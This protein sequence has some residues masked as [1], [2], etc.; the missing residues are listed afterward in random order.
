[1]VLNNIGGKTS[2]K[3]N[4][5]KKIN[6]VLDILTLDILCKYV[7]TQSRIIRLNHLVNLR[8]MIL[9]L[10]PVTYENDIEKQKR[11]MFIIKA[12]EARI[13]K[14]LSD[15]TA[16]LVDINGGIAYDLDFIDYNNLDLSQDELVWV[17]NLISETIQ[18]QFLYEKSNRLQDI[19]TRFTTS[20]YQNRAG[21]V[22]EFES[23]IDE[24]KND[25][26]HSK[27]EDNLV[28]MTFSLRPEIFEGAVSDTYNLVKNP[29]RRLICGMAGLNEM[30]GGG[31]ESGRVYMLLG[32]TG[33]GKSISLLNL[34]YQM[35]KYNTNYK[36][37]DPSKTPCIVLLTME[38]TVVETITRLF[39]LVT[40]SQGM[41]M[42][43]YSLNDVLYK[44][45]TEGGLVIDDNSP[46]D[47]VI[48][49][50]PNKSVDT[51]YLYTL[52]D[53]LEDE[54]YEVICLVQ[55]HVK[56]IRSIYG[57]QD[58]RL[59]LG[60]IVNELKVFA[61]DRDIPVL[62]NS[63]LNRDAARVVEDSMNKTNSVDMTMKLGK[64]NIGESMLMLDNLD[65]AI[66]INIDF[67][68][69][70]NRY[71][72]YSLI[73]MRDKTERTY[74]AQP[75][76]EGSTIRMVEDVGGVPMFRERL[77]SL[78]PNI[79][80]SSTVRMTSVAAVTDLDSIIDSEEDK[81]DNAFAKVKPYNFSSEPSTTPTFIKPKVV[82]AVKVIE[83]PLG[84]LDNIQKI[85]DMSVARESM[86]TPGN[87]NNLVRQ[88]KQIIC[89]IK[90]DDGTPCWNEAI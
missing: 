69:D 15:R 76:M 80:R 31:F 51:S 56:R 11:V 34:M 40:D 19:C 71:M 7:L 2:Y 84:L 82:E 20:T 72:C 13:D 52:C 73:K 48:K 17:G 61:A 14:H 39:D 46:I 83:G 43:D 26:R 47:I 21:I 16:I 45:R 49:Y 42:T 41:R 37:K 54:G 63:H 22:R 77:H 23:I 44:L 35:K 85:H 12:L 55:D 75:F 67:D 74:I 53:D 32:L 57:S 65:C 90:F 27:I 8:K 6:L 24:L 62:T 30:V 50:K 87:P 88:S 28:N 79:Q 81:R 60:D 33:V 78:N 36:P 86:F 68:Q 3:S 25:F 89:P 9:A 58:I 4:Q 29:S 5:S 38:N 70:N 1:M 64:S 10:D 66:I 18:Y 59:E